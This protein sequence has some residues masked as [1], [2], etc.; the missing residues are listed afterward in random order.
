MPKLEQPL[1]QPTAEM[2]IEAGKDLDDCPEVKR[3]FKKLWPGAFDNSV[4]LDIHSSIKCAD[5]GGHT[6]LVWVS[7]SGKEIWL[8]RSFNWERSEGGM[9][10][11]P[12]RK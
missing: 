11:T 10:L 1:E 5:H 3:A 2:V 4:Q 8:N 9:L 7:G 6:S 12:T